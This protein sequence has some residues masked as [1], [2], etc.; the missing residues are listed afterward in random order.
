[1]GRLAPALAWATPPNRHAA[2]AAMHTLVFITFNIESILSIYTSSAGRGH[3]R[4]RIAVGQGVEEALKVRHVL[5][6]HMRR[7][8]HRQ[9]IERHVHAVEVDA[10][11]GRQIIEL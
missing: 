2:A 7:V 4:R 11:G 10:I 1:M 8:A 6:T 3:G 9:T 5:G